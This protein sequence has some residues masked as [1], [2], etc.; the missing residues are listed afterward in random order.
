MNKWAF[1]G[2]FVLTVVAAMSWVASQP[3]VPPEPAVELGSDNPADGVARGRKV[4]PERRLC[5]ARLQSED[6]LLMDV[7]DKLQRFAGLS[8]PEAREAALEACFVD[9]GAPGK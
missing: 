5:R 3:E 6:P 1:V 7:V 9:L 2:V 4:A 8:A